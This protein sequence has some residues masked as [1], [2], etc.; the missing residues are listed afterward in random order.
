MSGDW[1]PLGVHTYS[2]ANVVNTTFRSMHL[3]VELAD[4]S[5]LGMVRFENVSL[6]DVTLQKGK[7]VSTT[8]NDGDCSTDSGVEYY[9]DDDEGYDVDLAPVQP[10]DRVKLGIDFVIRQQV[11][12]DC[13]NVRVR[14]DAVLPGCPQASTHKRADIRKRAKREQDDAA[15]R[16]DDIGGSTAELETLFEDTLLRPGSPWL[17]ALRT[18]L[19]QLPRAPP[20]WPPFSQPPP[21]TSNNRS[22]LTTTFPVPERVLPE[23]S[24]TPEAANATAA[25][26]AAAA[27]RP[28]QP[29]GGS[30]PERIQTAQVTVL[31]IVGALVVAAALAALFFAVSE[32]RRARSKA[33]GDQSKGA[34]RNGR[35]RHLTQSQRRR[36][37]NWWTSDNFDETMVRSQQAAVIGVATCRQPHASSSRRESCSLHVHAMMQRNNM[38]RSRSVSTIHRHDH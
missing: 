1:A 10:E 16:F 9:S 22:T 23:L 38:L 25:V 6:A 32:L 18:A 35:G 2:V 15:D 33:C 37:W 12:S 27:A 11:M 14:S 28:P 5:Y 8:K 24:L 7:V 19:G 13:V 29:V 3:S 36:R 30:T 20:E 17:Q 26:L 21:A 34:G 31:A 4:V